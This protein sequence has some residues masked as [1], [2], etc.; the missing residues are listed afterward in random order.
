MRCPI[1]RGNYQYENGL[2][3][4]VCK[5]HQSWIITWCNSCGAYRF[6]DVRGVCP[7]CME[8]ALKGGKHSTLQDYHFYPR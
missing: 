6:S 3:E 5:R 1:C 7:A 8:Q 4:E 2:E